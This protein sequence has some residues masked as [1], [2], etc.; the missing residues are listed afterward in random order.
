MLETIREFAEEQLV[1]RGVG[2]EVRDAHARHFAQRII[3][4]LNVWDS[5]EQREAYR[6]FTTELANLRTAF[7]CAADHADLDVATAIATYAAFLGYSID[8]FE[9]IS[10]AEELLEPAR[11]AGHRRLTFLYVMASMCY[12]AGRLEQAVKYA[13]I[14]EG[15]I[16]EGGELP[17]GLHA[18]P[19]APFTVSGMRRGITLSREQLARGLDSH[20]ISR[21]C[22]VM[23]LSIEGPDEEAMALCDGLIEAAEAAR[24]PMALCFALLAEGFAF[25]D[26][27]PARAL[28]A[29]RRGLAIA[30]DTGNQSAVSHSAAVLC[31]VECQ[32]GD[33]LAAL[34][35][36]SI[37]IQNHNEAGST[38]MIS[39]PLAIL[40]A[41]L[42]RM[43]RYEAAATIAGWAFSPV[44]STSFPTLNT[45]IA[46]L[47]EV[48]GDDAYERCAADGAAMNMAA[49]ANY[50][51]DQIDQART[52]LA[53]A[54]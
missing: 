46:H 36:F 15:L 48:L 9:P 16:N 21:G 11:A 43:G 17:Y 19:S 13:E 45:A 14:A 26:T 12:S 42:D 51:F 2:P 1:R 31:R 25:R 37:A 33:P 28:T 4:I 41:F 20:T 38:A 5:P 52:E 32:H 6:W 27:D 50:A 24:N 22:L 49:M 54:R 44:T 53:A 10:W 34:D 18:W 23:A 30:K 39:T 29:M 7:R 8:K 35:Y 40:A 47:R 3:D